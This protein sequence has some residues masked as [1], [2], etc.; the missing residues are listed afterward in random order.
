M[1]TCTTCGQRNPET[2]TFC[3]RCGSFLEWT[4]Q[5]DDGPAVSSTGPGPVL[6]Q[7]TRPVRPTGGDRPTAGPA[8]IAALGQAALR[9]EPGS[10]VSV[11]VDVRNNG[12]TVDRITVEILGEVARWASVQP[13]ALNLLP[14][15]RQNVTITFAPP[16][17]SE[18]L[19]GVFDT[20]IV[21]RS[22]EH[23]AEPVLLRA[24]V[25]IGAFVEY[26][27]DMTPR[28]ARARHRGRYTIRATNSGNSP[29]TIAVTGTD[30]EAVLRF[31]PPPGGI[32]VPPGATT[33]GILRVSGPGWRFRGSARTWPFQV[34]LT[35]GS[36]PP[37]SGMPAPGSKRVLDGTLIQKVAFYGRLPLATAIVGAA[38]AAYAAIAIARPFGPEFRLPFDLP[39]LSTTPVAVSSPAPTEARP[40]RT[41]EPPTEPPPSDQPPPTEPPPTDQ[42]PTET[43][44][45]WWADA[46]AEASSAGFDL[47]QPTSEGT[48]S[49]GMRYEDFEAGEV[50]E[51]SSGVFWVPGPILDK[52][53][54]LG[55][56]GANAGDLGYPITSLLRATDG[57]H[58]RGMFDRGSVYW[59]QNG[60]YAVY[61]VVWDGML[62][63]LSGLDH[64]RKLNLG[65]PDFTGYPNAD[66]QLFPDGTG[67]QSFETGYLWVAD[68]VPGM[69]TTAN[70]PRN[71]KVPVCTDI[72]LPSFVPVTPLPTPTPE[73]TPA[74]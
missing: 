16:R 62:S 31:A 29:L 33:S 38:V 10:Q 43:P 49:E 17:S 25:E 32:G 8:V 18:A 57:K 14:D 71:R 55:G 47:G 4:G 44:A 24:T 56:G 41:A 15:S 66:S 40:P 30:P 2:E 68:G 72:P 35:P 45:A 61:G 12:R 27:V 69:C 1:L 22:S 70:D 46:A 48:T 21:V 59:D 9:V 11:S 37:G 36:G 7:V 5:R 39:W 13:V 64:V 3:S 6:P 23:P 74:P 42:P 60:T 67:L 52:W 58:R 26:E 19:A 65:I 53:R 28:I 51:R 50:V 54:G 73:P 34:T 20:G 63:L